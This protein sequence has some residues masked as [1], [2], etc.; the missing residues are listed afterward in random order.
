[1]RL[2]V[3]RRYTIL[4]ILKIALVTALLAS[5]ILMGVDLFSHLDTYMN[6][7]IGF[8]RAMAI[9]TLYFPQAIL[10]AL[11]PSFLFAVSYHLSMMQSNNET[12]IIMDSG[13][14]MA[15]LVRPIIIMGLIFVVI[16]FLLNE[17]LAIPMLNQKEVITGNIS[18][19]LNTSDNTDI[20][21]SD[22][23][24]GYMVYATTYSDI[25]QSLYDVSLVQKD[26]QGHLISRVDA[27]KAIYNSESGLWTFRD[28]YLYIPNGD[29]VDV[30]YVQ[31][32][33]SPILKLEPQLFRNYTNEISNM[34]L[35]LARIYLSRMKSLSPD[36]YPS[37]AT[38][39]Y[40]RILSCL[41]P[42]VM[43]II[44]CSI[45][46]RFKKNVLFFSLITSICIAV[47]YYVVHI[48]T[49]MLAD[50]GVIAP[51]MGM[52]IP[53]MAILVLSSVLRAFFA[54]H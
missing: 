34:S 12:I 8:G 10:L 28:A 30:T 42:L 17:F 14:S 1:M 49:N 29:R 16:S 23:Q 43:I 15:K 24:E 13:I 5:L 50:Q 4:S 7:G 31:D 53:F 44:A 25:N 47:V 40:E 39:Y 54:K 22:M 20:A 52:I 32:Y 18:N 3:L 38:K 46:Y 21:L 9:T 37:L 41:T 33:E 6:H 35:R 27:Y 11:G 19:N 2:W 45:N 48:M 36:Q 26:N 51:A